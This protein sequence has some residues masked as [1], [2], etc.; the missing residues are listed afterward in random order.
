[1]ETTSE[2][3]K[4]IRDGA[5]LKQLE[6]D[7]V[8]LEAAAADS[9]LWDDRAKAQETLQALTDVKDKIKLLNDFKVQV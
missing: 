1:M 6:E 5:G 8:K 3:V 4:E 7:L 9:S 2:R